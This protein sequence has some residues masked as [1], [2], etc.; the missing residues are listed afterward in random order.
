M[1]AKNCLLLIITLLFTSIN[2]LKAQEEDL[3]PDDQEEIVLSSEGAYEH[4]V[5]AI[6]PFKTSFYK[7]GATR[8][9]S[10]LEQVLA[11]EEVLSLRAQEAFYNSINKDKRLIVTVQNWR[12]TDSLLTGA[13]ID[14]RKARFVDQQQIASLLKVDALLIGQLISA[15]GRYSTFLL[16]NLQPGG[17]IFR[18][19]KLSLLLYDGRS[20]T[21]FWSYGKKIN[22][23]YLFNRN[24]CLS[25]E[26]Y[27][28]F[29][30]KF[31]Y[32]R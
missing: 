32:T 21:P 4:K 3:L 14:L 15:R 16:G 10:T 6:L 24:R 9:D 22:V 7:P 13:G 26:L 8:G 20:G 30:R 5:I 28:F 2:R 29:R 11:E 27:S 1:T 25:D 19:R 31:P 17:K 23:N 12:V 18:L